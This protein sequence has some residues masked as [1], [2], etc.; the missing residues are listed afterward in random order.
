MDKK[1]HFYA[2]R[3]VAAWSLRIARQWKKAWWMMSKL[4]PNP[5]ELGAQAGRSAFLWYPAK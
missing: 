4:Q 3:P 1:S 5:S 2:F